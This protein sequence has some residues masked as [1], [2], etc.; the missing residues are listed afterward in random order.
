MFEK[1]KYYVNDNPREK[2][3]FISTYSQ[4]D[5][6]Y[7]H[8]KHL[9]EDYLLENQEQGSVIRLPNLIG[10]GTC[11]FFREGKLTPFGE[12]ELMTLS[13][14]AKEVLDFAENSTTRVYTIKREIVSAKLVKDLIL[15]GMDGK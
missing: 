11:E 9:S 6:F 8:Y 15:F 1:F 13:D 14:A 5:N 2:I 12:M 3:V 4:A 7:K 10:K